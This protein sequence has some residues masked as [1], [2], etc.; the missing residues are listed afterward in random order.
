MTEVKDL[1]PEKVK[2]IREEFDF[3]DKDKNGEID[4]HEFFDLLRVISPKAKES[5]ARE[6]FEMIDE[7]GDGHIDFDEFLTWWQ[8][9]WWEY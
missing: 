5:S 9:N 4:F 7:N 8:G 2:Q 3:F 1:D 6:G